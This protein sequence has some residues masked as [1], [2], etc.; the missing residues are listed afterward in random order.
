MGLYGPIWSNI[1]PRG[2]VWS[3]VVPC[4]PKWSSM[5]PYGSLLSLS[6]LHGPVW[7]PCLKNHNYVRYA[8]LGSTHATSAQILCLFPTKTVF[9]IFFL[10]ILEYSQSQEEFL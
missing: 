3:H 9:A 6:V 1:V 2:L 10:L 4:A 7:F 5:V 8:Y